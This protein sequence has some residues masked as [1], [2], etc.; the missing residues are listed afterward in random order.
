MI[1]KS[2]GGDGGEMMMIN[3]RERVKKDRTVKVMRER[4]D[5]VEQIM[6]VCVGV[7]AGI[8]NGE[9]RHRLEEE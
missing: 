8:V 4:G 2:V 6:S 7:E 5:M 1:H 9:E 3:C